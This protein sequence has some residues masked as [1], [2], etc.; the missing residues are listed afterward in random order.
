MQTFVSERNAAFP[1]CH[2]QKLYTVPALLAFFLKMPYSPAFPALL[3]TQITNLG[4]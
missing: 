4:I 1:A 3:D 2:C